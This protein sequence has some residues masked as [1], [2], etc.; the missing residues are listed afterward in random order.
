MSN[1]S[2][3]IETERQEAETEA[4]E[5]KPGPVPPLRPLDRYGF[6]KANPTEVSSKGQ[7]QTER[8]RYWFF[9]SA[10]DTCGHIV[11]SPPYVL[12]NQYLVPAWLWQFYIPTADILVQ[13]CNCDLSISVAKFISPSFFALKSWHMLYTS[14]PCMPPVSHNSKKLFGSWQVWNFEA[15]WLLVESRLFNA[16]YMCFDIGGWTGRSEGW[17]SGGEWLELGA[18]TGSTICVE[19]HWL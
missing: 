3:Q 4:L 13:Y 17:E 1:G 15:G 10:W 12:S 18:G 11:S 7:P 8:E 9:F 16:S 6:V 14:Y 19:S 2:S 5:F